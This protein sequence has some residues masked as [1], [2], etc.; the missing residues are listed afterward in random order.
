M[1]IEGTV[2]GRSKMRRKSKV[3]FVNGR[4]GNATLKRD[5]RVSWLFDSATALLFFLDG[6]DGMFE[7]PNPYWLLRFA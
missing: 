5:F 6:K 3:Y 2:H 7:P 4:D 1:G